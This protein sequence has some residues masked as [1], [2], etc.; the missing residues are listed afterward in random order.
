MHEE[1]AAALRDKGI[2]VCTVRGVDDLR[3]AT[4]P[5]VV[6][7]VRDGIVLADLNHPMA[8]YVWWD[9][10]DVPALLETVKQGRVRADGL[11]IL[12]SLC[13]VL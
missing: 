2:D 3:S 6:Y 4:S 11:A 10:A 8:A 13:G 12:A 7:P 9:S 1:F 5:L